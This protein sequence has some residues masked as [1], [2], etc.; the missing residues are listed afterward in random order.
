M[1]APHFYRSDVGLSCELFVGFGGAV[2]MSTASSV[3]H[4]V[5]PGLCVTGSVFAGS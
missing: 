1:L 5:L 2:G 3:Y 4:C